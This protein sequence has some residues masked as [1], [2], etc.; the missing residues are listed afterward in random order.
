[1]KVTHSEP[2]SA[3]EHVLQ[4]GCGSTSRA[5]KFYG[6]QVLGY[7]NERMQAFVAAAQML[8]I[9][10]ADGAGECDCSF[11][12]G[13]PG[14][15]KVL[16]ADTIAYPEYRGNGVMASLGNMLQNPH[17]GILI[18]DFVEALIGL[19]INGA[20]SVLDPVQA[21]RT[22]PALTA[23]TG[24]P[25]CQAEHW[26]AVEVHEA[27]IHCRKHLPRFQR[28]PQRRD[29]GTDDP[30]RKGGD[31]FGAATSLRLTDCNLNGVTP[32]MKET[33]VTDVTTDQGR[34]PVELSAADGQLLRELTER[35]RGRLKLTGAGGPAREADQDGGRGALEDEMDDHLGCEKNDPAGQRAVFTSPEK[36]NPQVSRDSDE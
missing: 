20:A 23:D 32:E 26:V 15:I 27:Y 34:E 1:M 31:Y 24:A 4:E 19:H 33:L 12:A 16:G 29:W 9:A 35:A 22:F 3:G 36:E 25:G 5:A 8:F 17:I 10:T 7:L 2:G 30:H 14:F 11:R 21:N 28:V 6:T 13:P 18:V